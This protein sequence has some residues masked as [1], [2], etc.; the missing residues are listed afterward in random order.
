MDFLEIRDLVVEYNTN[1]RSLLSLDRVSFKVQRGEFVS[2]IGPS[3][4]GKS[5]IIKVLLG[6]IKPTSGTVL[7]ENKPLELSDVKIS[8]V[9]Q[10]S[11]LFPWLDVL[12]NVEVALE[13]ISKDQEYIRETAKKF[14]KIVGIDGFEDAYPRELSGGMKQRVAIARA[15]APGP[16]LLLLDEPFAALDVFTAQGLREELLDL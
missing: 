14:I 9:F 3:G 13:V 8:V 7:I 11:A 5:T 6:L 2:I 4:C 10:N 12:K 1:G 16:D 15:L